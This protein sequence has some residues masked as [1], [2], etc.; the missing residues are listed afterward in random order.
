[1]EFIL[2]VYYQIEERKEQLLKK[3]EKI[4]RLKM[5]QKIHE[6]YKKGYIDYER[7]IIVFD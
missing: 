2:S 1:M 3:Q 7:N 4:N 6:F 5:I